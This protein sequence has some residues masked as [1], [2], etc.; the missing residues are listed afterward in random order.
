MHSK[1]PWGKKGQGGSIERDG[2]QNDQLLIR[3]SELGDA[4]DNNSAWKL[5]RYAINRPIR[6]IYTEYTLMRT[7]SVQFSNEKRSR[8]LVTGY[9]DFF[10]KFFLLWHRVK[11]P[12]RYLVVANSEVPV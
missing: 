1:T 11:Y 2:G 6:P 8:T 12:R 7:K 9:F 10:A 3:H 4:L 5:S